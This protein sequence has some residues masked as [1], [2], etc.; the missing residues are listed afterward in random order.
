MT[1]WGEVLFASVMTNEDTRTLAVGLQSYATRAGVAWN[2][3]MAAS[4]VVSAPV[5]VG[6][7]ILQRYLIRGLTTGAVK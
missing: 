4:L 5:M 2:Q 1:A 3:V 6:F 7:L